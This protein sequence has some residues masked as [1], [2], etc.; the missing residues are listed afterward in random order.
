MSIYSLNNILMFT[1]A[2]KTPRTK[3]GLEI[4]DFPEFSGGDATLSFEQV[5]PVTIETKP[6]L[7]L[8]FVLYGSLPLS[9]ATYSR[10]LFS[11]SLLFFSSFFFLFSFSFLSSSLQIIYFIMASAARPQVTV[12]GTDSQVVMPAVFLA[13]IRPDIVGD[14]HT[15]MA[16]NRR[17]AYAVSPGAGHKHSAKSWGTGRAV[18]R[19]PRVSGSGTSRAG[20]AAFG[21]MCRKG[22]MFAPTKTFRKWHIK[23]NTNQKR[24]AVVSALAASALPALVMARGHRVE[25]VSEVPCV[26]PDKFESVTKTKAAIEFLESV[27]A[28]DDIAKAKDSRKVRTGKGKMRNRRFTQRRGPLIVFNN[29]DGLVQA[30]RNIP[31]VEVANVERLNLLQLAPGG[32]LGRFIIFTESAFRRLDGIY[33]THTKKST[34][35]YNYKLPTNI[36]TNSDITRII[37]SD[38]IQS[39]VRAPIKHITKARRKKNPLK[40]LGVMVRLN[41]YAMAARRTELR[42]AERAAANKTANGVSAVDRAHRKN[43][44]PTNWARISAN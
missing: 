4:R 42:N 34:A 18:S 27:G 33:G 15:A 23:I 17:Q 3:L 24:Y 32:H 2:T 22:R 9:F 25:S 10:S 13:P 30:V 43:Q 36:M 21:N 37:N 19:I 31:G 39:K 12:Q 35:K 5:V 44:K 7:P 14:V 40:N 41:P 20:Q 1:F 29:D 26:V 28:G 6:K 8:H 11:L 16:K 38:E